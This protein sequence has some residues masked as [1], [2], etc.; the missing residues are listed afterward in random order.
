[1][2]GKLSPTINCASLMGTHRVHQ[3]ASA[4]PGVVEP[5]RW[6]PAGLLLAAGVSGRDPVEVYERLNDVNAERKLTPFC[7]LNIDPPWWS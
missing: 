6:Q 3:R 4:V 7:R 1:M 2:L 5:D